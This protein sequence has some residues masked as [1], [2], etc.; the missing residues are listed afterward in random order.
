LLT[1][2]PLHRSNTHDLKYEKPFPA[3][4]SWKDIQDIL[5]ESSVQSNIFAI[6]DTCFAGNLIKGPMT[7]ET[8]IFE[9]LAAAGPNKVTS[10]PGPRSFT[11][12]LMNSL[13]KLLQ[14]CGDHGQFNS[15]E[16]HNN[17]ISTATRRNNP[18]VLFPVIRQFNRHLPL[19]P[20]RDSEGER[21]DSFRKLD[22]K[23]FLT[24]RFALQDKRLTEDHVKDL[25]KYLAVGARDSGV[26]IQSIDWLALRYSP[27]LRP[28]VLGIRAMVAWKKAIQV[29]TALRSPVRTNSAASFK[30]MMEGGVGGPPILQK[31]GSAEMGGHH[32]EDDEGEGMEGVV[33]LLEPN[34][35]R[36]RV[37]EGALTE[38]LLTPGE[39]GS[40]VSSDLDG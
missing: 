26:K 24:L 39:T 6:L 5:I 35:K 28:T 37:E 1:E 27:R 40:E 34:V 36:A 11:R 8:K 21:A 38:V 14:T 13:E 16:L 12:A 2:A 25:V 31:R 29:A 3:V 20:L 30:M 18:P 9:V 7:E 4:V 10:G 23:A 17:I 32:D 33:G 15:W 22:A 19:S